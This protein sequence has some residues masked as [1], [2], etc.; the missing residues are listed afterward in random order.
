[1]IYIVLHIVDMT[2]ILTYRH[3]FIRLGFISGSLVPTH[4]YV[5]SRQLSRVNTIQRNRMTDRHLTQG[6]QYRK[7]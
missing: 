4:I 6:K 7:I 2:A 1:M 5:S 3:T